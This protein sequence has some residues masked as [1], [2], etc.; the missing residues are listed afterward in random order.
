[1][2]GPGES[3]VL[4][5]EWPRQSGLERNYRGDLY[6]PADAEEHVCNIGSQ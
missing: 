4:L 6:K 3:Q 2:I 5:G 1:M